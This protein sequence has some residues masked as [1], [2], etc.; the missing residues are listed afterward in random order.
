MSTL[1]K[2]IERFANGTADAS[3]VIEALP[4]PKKTKPKPSTDTFGDL[5]DPVGPAT[6]EGTWDEVA[7][8]FHRGVLSHAQY[9]ELYEAYLS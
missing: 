6:I 3:E 7:S 4:E 5:A 1:S 2:A 8:A 9:T